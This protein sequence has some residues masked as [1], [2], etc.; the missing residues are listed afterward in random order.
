[1]LRKLALLRTIAP[2]SLL[3]LLLINAFSMCKLV[4]GY[5]AY[6]NICDI[7]DQIYVKLYECDI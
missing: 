3:D 6:L 7:S 2:T 5:M 1:M 4:M